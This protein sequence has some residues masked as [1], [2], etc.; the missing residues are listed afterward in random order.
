VSPLLRCEENGQIV[1]HR[2]AGS[3]RLIKS[4]KGS[5]SKRINNE[6]FILCQTWLERPNNNIQVGCRGESVI[7]PLG[8]TTHDVTRPMKSFFLLLLPPHLL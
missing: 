7:A 1:R 8:K 3:H 6:M 5:P 4:Q 2:R